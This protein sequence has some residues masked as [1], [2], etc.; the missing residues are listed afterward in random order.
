MIQDRV[1][2]LKHYNTMLI[3]L[4]PNLSVQLCLETEF[5]RLK[6]VRYYQL[7]PLNLSLTGRVD[8]IISQ[9]WYQTS[10]STLMFP[11]FQLLIFLLLTVDNAVLFSLLAFLST[12][13]WGF[14]LPVEY[15]PSLMT[16]NS[17]SQAL[18]L[19]RIA[20]LPICDKLSNGPKHVYVL[21]LRTCECIADTASCD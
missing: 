10:D 21:T 14:H 4:T 1:K 19:P 6:S 15:Q 20:T 7:C 9:N 12:S 11:L 2:S 16:F 8:Q 17:L 13:F 5:F 18:P 3:S